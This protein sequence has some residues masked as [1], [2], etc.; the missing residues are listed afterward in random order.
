MKSLVKCAVVLGL[1][2]GPAAAQDADLAIDAR[3]GLMQVYRI[4]LAQ[5][6]GM[7]KGEVD[8][9]AERASALAVS[10]KAASSVDQMAMWPQGS[11]QGAMG[12]KT[13]A[14]ADLWTTFPAVME[15]SGKFSE[16]VDT[17][18]AEAGNGQ[19]ALG[20][21][22]GGVGKSCG[23]CHKPYRASNK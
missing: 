16:A 10:L 14:L 21:A 6:S 8:Y 7:A 18:V 23:G 4:H 5:L 15:V 12:D 22:L 2:A 1:L 19:A 13:R 3:K 9:D 11:D 20:A 17:L